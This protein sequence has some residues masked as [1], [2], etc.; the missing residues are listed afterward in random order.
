MRNRKIHHIPCVGSSMLLSMLFL[1]V[2]A[3]WTQTQ[4]PATAP[5]VQEVLPSYEGQTVVSI[6]IAGRPDL[7]Q[8]QLMLLLA[9][10]ERQPFS[11]SKIDQS[12][13]ALKTSG[14]VKEVQLEIRPQADGVRLLL[15]CQ[16]AIYFGV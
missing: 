14:Q 10:R 11:R 7:D 9:Q 2:V 8:R 16:P 6:E 12:I 3:G 13:A 5:Q 1:A 15:V 4:V